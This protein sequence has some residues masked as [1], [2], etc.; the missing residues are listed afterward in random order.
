MFGT[1]ETVYHGVPVVTLPVFADQ[2]SNAMKVVQEGYGI[3][4]ELMQL[5]EQELVHAISEVATNPRYKAAAM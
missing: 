3:R 2:D 1:Q 4:L 5:T